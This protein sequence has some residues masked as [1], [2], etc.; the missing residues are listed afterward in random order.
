M[1]LQLLV[2]CH[3]EIL[4][5]V[6]RKQNNQWISFTFLQSFS[7]SSFFEVEGVES[8]CRLFTNKKRT[9]VHVLSSS[10]CFLL[11][12]WK[13]FY[14]L[15][16]FLILFLVIYRKNFLKYSCSICL[17]VHLVLRCITTLFQLHWVIVLSVRIWQTLCVS[18]GWGIHY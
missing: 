15:P 18:Q 13:V 6:L 8:H 11:P 3:L 5:D 10:P 17:H 2:N 9:L 4:M 14:V 1:I 12:H 16:V 7:Y